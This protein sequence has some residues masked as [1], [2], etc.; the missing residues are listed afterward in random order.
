ML[1]LSPTA[2][3]ESFFTLD[4]EKTL[5]LTGAGQLPRSLYTNCPPPRFPFFSLRKL[6]VILRLKLSRRLHLPAG[7]YPFPGNSSLSLI[8]SPDPVL[9][10]A[11]TLRFIADNTSAVPI[12]KVVFA[13]SREGKSYTI[14]R[15]VK[16]ECLLTALG[17]LSDKTKREVMAQVRVI[18]AEL[19]SLRSP[20]D[21]AVANVGMG[22]LRYINGRLLGDCG[23]IGPFA[24]MDEFHSWLERAV[25]EGDEK[26]AESVR[27]TL[28]RLPSK[29]LKSVFTHGAFTPRNIFVKDG[30]VVGVVGWSGAG[31]WPPYWECLSA[32]RLSERDYLKREEIDWIIFPV[33][34]TK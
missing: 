12:P 2:S 28:R 26:F 16:G 6:A 32:R 17:G 4:D 10:E 15:K 1:E 7:T 9:S 30:K 31:W 24:S 11:T 29:P 19:K 13:F 20:E 14:T 22:P 33:P 34:D 27:A 5:C 3:F 25:E 18:H 8:I 21:I 23:L